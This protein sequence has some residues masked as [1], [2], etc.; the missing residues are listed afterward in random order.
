MI[1][2]CAPE[3]GRSETEAV[4][5]AMQRNP[6]KAPVFIVVES[7]RTEEIFAA[8]RLGAVDFAVPP[9]RSCD[10]IPRLRRLRDNNGSERNVAA[11][12]LKEEL[13]LTQFI[14]ESPAF[15]EAI[16]SI[17]KLA[18]CSA[19]V[20]IT[21]ETGTG[22]EMIARAVHYLGHVRSGGLNSFPSI[23]GPSRPSWWKT[24]CSVTNAALLRAPHRRPRVSSHG[25]NGGTIYFSMR[26]ILFR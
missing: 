19:T 15:M 16:K 25:A 9:F 13:G 12:Q 17:P 20:L 14:G 23:A 10:L 22:K 24:N 7:G 21:G 26:L 2:L 1:V 18:R 8:L 6:W 3:Q 11:S 4:L 5:R